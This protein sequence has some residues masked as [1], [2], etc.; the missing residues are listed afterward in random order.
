MGPPSMC[1]STMKKKLQ[2]SS[3]MIS[4][5]R[6]RFLCASSFITSISRRIASG[7]QA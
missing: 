3:L 6:T 4:M 1:S 7:R 5:S 2:S